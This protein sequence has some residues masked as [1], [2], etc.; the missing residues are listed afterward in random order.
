M[1]ES[2]HILDQ[3][4]LIQEYAKENMVRPQYI[5]FKNDLIQEFIQ[6][7]NTINDTKK[8]FKLIQDTYGPKICKKFKD[9]YEYDLVF[10][11]MDQN[12]LNDAI[13]QIK[14]GANIDDVA[15]ELKVW[16]KPLKNYLKSRNYQYCHTISHDQTYDIFNQF[17]VSESEL[18]GNFHDSES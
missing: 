13:V 4:P 15:K 9:K 2:A 1:D 17:I 12:K 7:I 10:Q 6:L 3:Y 18:W 8:V 16:K 5:R 14:N 11:L